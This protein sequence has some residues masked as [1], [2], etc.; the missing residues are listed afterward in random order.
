MGLRIGSG[1]GHTAEVFA[2]T[3]VL[4]TGGAGHTPP[5]T[6]LGTL[7]AEVVARAVLNAVRAATGLPGLPA[8]AALPPG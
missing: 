5:M 3:V 7:A 6:V 2:P 1:D 4:A 8:A